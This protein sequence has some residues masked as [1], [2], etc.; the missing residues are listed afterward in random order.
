MSC[1]QVPE[2]RFTLR[3]GFTPLTL[4]S[5]R[6]LRAAFATL[7]LGPCGPMGPCSPCGPG[8]RD[9]LGVL[10]GRSHQEA[11][12]HPEVPVL[13]EGRGRPECLFFPWGRLGQPVRITLRPYGGAVAF[14]AHGA[15]IPAD[16]LRS[17][18]SCVSLLAPTPL[19]TLR[20]QES[21]RAHH[22][23]W[24][25]G[26]G[27]ALL[28]LCPWGTTL[29]RGRFTRPAFAARS[30]GGVQPGENGAK[31]LTR[32]ESLSGANTMTLFI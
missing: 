4:G 32:E 24:A 1:P 30:P 15:G 23:F 2:A 26:T 8:Q 21:L 18:I 9:L 12:A 11:L 31:T 19:N 3:A 22:S 29:S 5:C 7:A 16:T 27:T 25:H 14:G 13:L 17:D 20:P 6:T 28:T 10:E